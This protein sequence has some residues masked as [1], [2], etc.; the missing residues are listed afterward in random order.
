MRSLISLTAMAV[1]AGGAAAQATPNTLSTGF[2]PTF[3]SGA[4]DTTTYFDLT[5]T[6]PAGITLF[7]IGHNLNFAAGQTTSC[8]VYVVDMAEAGGVTPTFRG[9]ELI[10]AFWDNDLATP[11]LEPDF[12]SSIATAGANLPSPGPIPGGFFLA[13]GTYAIAIT[14]NDG[15]PL[16]TTFS[17]A[18]GMFSDANLA[19]DG[20]SVS[21]GRFAGGLFGASGARI[22]NGDINYFSG[23]VP[24]AKAVSFGDECPAF[25][26]A[27]LVIEQFN[28][29]GGAPSDISG[30]EIC[31][32]P[33]GQ[34]GYTVTSTA[35]SNYQ[36][37]SGA[38]TVLMLGDDVLS[39]PLMLA[40][41]VTGPGGTTVTSIEIDSNGRV[42]F[43]T[44]ANA[45]TIG[46]PGVGDFLNS[47]SNVQIGAD[48]DPSVG[49]TVT[50][51]EIGTDVLV[52][53]DA[54][55]EFGQ[56]STFTTQIVLNANGVIKFRL[57]NYFP[58]AVS[59]VGVAQ[60]VGFSDF[61]TVVPATDL[62]ATA[63]AAVDTGMSSI[64]IRATALTTPVLG[65]SLDVVL[66]QVPPTAIGSFL[67]LGFSNP[68]LDLTALGAPGCVLRSSGESTIPAMTGGVPN[69]TPI[70]PLM[71]LAGLQLFVQAA[72]LDPGAGN[73]FFISLGNGIDV[74]IQAQ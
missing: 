43:D 34:G 64:G 45:A 70:P 58:V 59:N 12:A 50:I 60:G 9:N 33:N 19:F 73:P 2:M 46:G 65:S 52:S 67:L 28:A 6:D 55:P 5:V 7:D 10:P 15:A 32:T 1:L 72:A 18:N 40:N 71:G 62:S 39:G 31:F 23:N 54:V 16:Y 44:T 27:S 63:M 69:V 8:E 4:V 26:D 11:E 24:V 13:P 51:E 30:T 25:N 3:F 57:D 68:G 36:A 61:A 21:P 47:V 20:G 22:W 38:A 48:Y 17:G 37:P 74:C 56:P 14:Y 49:G 29:A 41:A 53:W 66:E 42:L 35:G